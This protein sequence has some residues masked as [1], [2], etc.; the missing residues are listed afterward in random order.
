MSSPTSLV[1]RPTCEPIA[2]IHHYARDLHLS[3]TKS[4]KLTTTTA[5][6]LEY[7]LSYYAADRA[8]NAPR[9]QLPLPTSSQPEPEALSEPSPR[10]H[11]RG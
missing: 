4:D 3:R 2:R 7:T 1:I 10:K 11:G 5:T 9:R 6:P 8:T